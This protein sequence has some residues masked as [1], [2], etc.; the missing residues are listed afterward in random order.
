MTRPILRTLAVATAVGTALAATAL[1]AHAARLTLADPAGDTWS[2]AEPAEPAASAR[3]TD[4]RRTRIVHGDR[5]VALRVRYSDLVRPRRGE[6]ITLAVRLRTNDG[7]K[8]NA[9]VIARAASPRGQHTLVVERNQATVSCPGLR[10]TIGYAA[11]VVVLSVPRTCLGNPRWVQLM[12]VALDLDNR[13]SA[14][15]VD[16]AAST[17]SEPTRWTRR[18]RKG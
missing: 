8:R 2:A 18:L 16:D 6:T 11:D 15:T 1:P 3:N 12:V 17:K 13:T 5:R 4:L 9:F 7:P 14:A 10:H